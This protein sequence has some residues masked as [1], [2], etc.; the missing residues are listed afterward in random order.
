[1]IPSTYDDGV[2]SPPSRHKYHSKKEVFEFGNDR[3]VTI[4][5]YPIKSIGFC[6]ST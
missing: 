2:K 5:D 3:Q 1:M 6:M 4:L